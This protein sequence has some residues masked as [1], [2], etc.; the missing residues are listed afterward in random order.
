MPLPSP[1][2]RQS[3][4]APR[5]KGAGGLAGV[6]H[7][8]AVSSCKGGVGKSTVAVNL[9]YALAQKDFK[10]GIFDADIHGPSLPTLVSPVDTT[11]RELNLGDLKLIVPPVYE[12]V[13][14]MSY[15]FV[16]SAEQR[17]QNA[18]PPVDKLKDPVAALLAA[19]AS[20]AAVMRGPMVSNVVHQLLRYTAWGDLDYLVLDMP[21]GT[22]DIQITLSQQVQIRAALIV[23]TPQ[24]L[25]FI[26]VVKGIDM[27]DKVNIPTVGVVENMVYYMCGNCSTKH[28]PFGAG[29]RRQVVDLFGIRNSFELPLDAGAY[30]LDFIYHYIL[31]C[32]KFK[33]AAH[34]PISMSPRV[35]NIAAFGRWR[36]HRAR[37]VARQRRTARHIPVYCRC[38]A[39][40]SAGAERDRHRRARLW[41]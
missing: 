7:I 29:Y 40:R 30:F 37:S 39:H 13:K 41:V 4:A 19:H 14:C 6:K 34:F 11:L 8:I 1:L 21:P 3:K 33:L 17:A 23:S 9:A 24:K 18:P 32:F 25:S 27:F 12:G 2:N 10:V 16:R 15:G 22:G 35:S 5:E 20:A 26:D 31:V 38:S 28:Y 36:S